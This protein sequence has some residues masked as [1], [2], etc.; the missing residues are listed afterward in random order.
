MYEINPKI[1]III[2]VYNVEKYLRECLDSI[3]NQTLKEFEVILVDDG[4]PDNSGIICDEYANRDSRFKVI[5]K[6]N[7]GVSAAR[8]T[9][10][11]EAKGK[12]VT[13]IDS[14][15]F[16]AKTFLENLYKPI[17]EGLKVD[18]VQGGCVNYKNG[19]VE[20]IEQ[21]YDY[22]YSTDSEALLNRF[23]GLAISKLLKTNII[24]ENN[25]VFDEKM[26]I[27]ED[28]AFTLDYIKH[29]SSYVFVPE[30]GY[31]Y[32]RDNVS[33]A[34]KSKRFLTYDEELHR[35]K[36]I[37]N[38]IEQYKNYHSLKEEQC[39]FRYSQCSDILMQAFFSLYRI[40]TEKRIRK[41]CLKS[42]ITE[43][44]RKVLK[45]YKGGFVQTFLSEIILKEKVGIFDFLTNVIFLLKRNY[46]LYYD[47]KD[48]FKN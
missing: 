19:E 5:H 9:G 17:T 42:A 12:W 36:H 25:I 37:Y 41:Q 32:R 24:A 20:S 21:Q 18:F 14:D 15:D 26:R 47:R 44:Q 13:F 45:Y 4:S 40:K 16:V 46:N 22:F 3:L 38:S 39:M 10:L 11:K 29:V 23:R 31:Y 34:T 8:N 6:K 33:S 1:S 7:A 43:N 48:Y 28:M 2:P 27:A 30:I 35:F